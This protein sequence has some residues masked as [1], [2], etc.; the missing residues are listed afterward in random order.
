LTFYIVIRRQKTEFDL[1]AMFTFTKTAT[2][3]LSRTNRPTR[4]SLEVSVRLALRRR[5]AY[6]HRHYDDVTRL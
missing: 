6:G 3:D 1:V 5:F 4:D 2:S